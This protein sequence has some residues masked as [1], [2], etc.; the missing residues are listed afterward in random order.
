MAERRGATGDD[1]SSNARTPG[2]GIFDAWWCVTIDRSIDR[3][4]T[5]Y[6]AFFHIACFMIV[7]KRVVQ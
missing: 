1:G 5:I 6:G 2:W 3:S 7:L 4:L